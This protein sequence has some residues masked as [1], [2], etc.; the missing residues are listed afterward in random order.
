MA[1]LLWV[2][3]GCESDFTYATSAFS[4]SSLTNPWNVGSARYLQGLGFKPSE[5][6]RRS[7]IL[8]NPQFSAWSAT[9]T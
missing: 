4:C 1:V 9:G 3:M 7:P 6:E 8:R 2:G 5:A